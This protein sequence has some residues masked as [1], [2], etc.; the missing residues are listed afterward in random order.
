MSRKRR[1]YGPDVSSSYGFKSMRWICLEIPRNV[2]YDR[3]LSDTA[4]LRNVQEIKC[5]EYFWYFIFRYYF[6]N[7][8]Y[9]EKSVSEYQYLFLIHLFLVSFILCPI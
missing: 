4:Y 3:S 2:S 5:V 7:I 1:I 6:S 8:S 9:I